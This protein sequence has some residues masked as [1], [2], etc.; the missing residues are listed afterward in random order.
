MTDWLRGKLKKIL[1]LHA[2]WIENS[3]DGERANLRGADL[4][5]ANIEFYL[6]PNISLLSS[7]N[8]GELSDGMTLELMRRDCYAHPFP[9]RFDEWVAGGDCPYTSELRFW[10]FKENKRLWRP[11][12][13]EMTDR[14]LIKAI[15]KEKGWRINGN[16][17]K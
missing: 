10:H 13:P 14:D 7:I 3:E 5:D 4:R 8:L 9:E 6:F 12:N 15:C 2:R 11:G 1:L 17:A 16:K